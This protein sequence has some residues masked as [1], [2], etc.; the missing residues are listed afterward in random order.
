M[1]GGGVLFAFPFRV[2][3]LFVCGLG[4]SLEGSFWWPAESLWEG[5]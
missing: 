4:V 1:A 5:G 2:F 3:K